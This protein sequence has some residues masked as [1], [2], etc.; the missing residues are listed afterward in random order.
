MWRRRA[1]TTS[2][3][4]VRTRL[5]L[6]AG[7]AFAVAITLGLF[8]I[9]VLT[10]LAPSWW[11]DALQLRAVSPDVGER[12]ERAIVSET[13]RARP[14]GETWAMAITQ[15]QANAWLRDRLPK[16]ASNRGV[17]AQ[18]GAAVRVRFVKDAIIIGVREREGGRVFSA[19][20]A[21]VLREDGSLWTRL[22]SVSA[23]RMPAPTGWALESLHSLTNEMRAGQTHSPASVLAGKAP[24]AA[25]A[26]ARLEDG[27]VVYPR[28][29]RV[30][31]G[32]LVIVWETLAPSRAASDR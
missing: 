1:A 14:A 20:V 29:V 25:K 26:E 24:A 28:E 13:H 3:T 19:C 31:P 15:E 32:R 6:R 16:W 11:G 9:A 21:P 4:E 17:R 30:E 8:A 2:R 27:R 22:R 18:P 7:L 12:I 5:A 10:S 23:G